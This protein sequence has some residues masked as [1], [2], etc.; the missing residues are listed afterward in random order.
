MTMEN[1]TNQCKPDKGQLQYSEEK[2]GL[3]LSTFALDLSLKKDVPPVSPKMFMMALSPTLPASANKRG[4]YEEI[5]LPVTDGQTI[6]AGSSA[7][8]SPYSESNSP[9]RMKT[10]SEGYHENSSQLRY[11]ATL[12]NPH[13][14]IPGIE[15]GAIP[16]QPPSPLPGLPNGAARPLTELLA[17]S[18]P[19]TETAQSLPIYNDAERN[20]LLA[21]PEFSTSTD[22]GLM[23]SLNPLKKT[24][25]PFKAYPKN[26]PP[27]SDDSYTNYI[28]FRERV[29]ELKRMH[30][31]TSNP[32]MRRVVKSPGL[33]TST[34]EEKDPAYLERRRKNNEAAKRSREARR[35]KEDELAIRATYLERENA[36]LKENFKK[37]Q[38]MYHKLYMQFCHAH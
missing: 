30:E 6:F 18:V 9:K 22:D 4:L 19:H 10:E 8:L 31:N 3:D 20:S 12:T 28:K 37:L 16:Q 25:R 1:S 24:P 29:I 35:V 33:P 32:R 11:N 2:D 36:Q 7:M 15:M 34:V 13:G 14:V 21:V 27:P 23:T 5:N 17:M 26:F 38:F